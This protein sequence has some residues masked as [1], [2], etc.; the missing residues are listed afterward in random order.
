[1]NAGKRTYSAFYESEEEKEE[2]ISPVS[3]EDEDICKPRWCTVRKHTYINTYGDAA[4]FIGL[5]F[6]KRK[7]LNRT[8]E[9]CFSTFILPYNNVQVCRER[10][11][12]RY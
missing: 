5:S 9:I 6:S 4:A 8:H 1:M 3:S 10:V 12:V 11:S 7:G 2:V